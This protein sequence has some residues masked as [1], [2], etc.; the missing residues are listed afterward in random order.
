M[1]PRDVV[2][3]PHVLMGTKARGRSSAVYDVRSSTLCTVGSKD[4][5]LQVQ[6]HTRKSDP[7]DKVSI[8]RGTSRG[9]IPIC[10]G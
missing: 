8:D 7:Q 4:E 3:V 1:F 9:F 6:P 10:E 2:A 5:Y